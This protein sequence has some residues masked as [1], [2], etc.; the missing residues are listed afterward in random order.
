M[1]DKAKI[2]P[3][4]NDRRR[5]SLRQSPHRKFLPRHG[6]RRL[7]SAPRLSS[8]RPFSDA[9]AFPRAS[10]ALMRMI[11]DEFD[12][13]APR[14]SNPAFRPSR[15]LG[16]NAGEKRPESAVQT[17]RA[18]PND[19]RR[20]LPAFSQRLLRAPF[21]RL[22]T[23]HLPRR[24]P[25]PHSRP[26]PPGSFRLRALRG[27]GNIRPFIPASFRPR[28]RPPPP[29]P[30]PPRNKT[31]P[32]QKRR[33]KSPPINAPKRPPPGAAPLEHF[34]RTQKSRVRPPRAQSMPLFRLLPVPAVPRLQK[35]AVPG[36]TAVD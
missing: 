8:L 12:S 19:T 13:S 18:R 33:P 17:R 9:P 26:L 15:V 22:R 5:R 7:G 24:I 2:V 11:S 34:R 3:Q 30:P 28:I 31:P 21:P 32:R 27:T 1:K 14:F 10:A 29:P 4:D 35:S 16:L 23:S 36:H 20:F 6:P 25:G